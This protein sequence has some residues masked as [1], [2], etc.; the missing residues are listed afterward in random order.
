MKIGYLTDA[1]GDLNFFTNYCKISEV[2]K[3]ESYHPSYISL[4]LNDDCYFVFGGDTTDKGPGD[5]R[6]CKSL[7]KLK[8]KYPERVFLI[9]GNRDANK[10]MISYE[11]Q[12]FLYNK[13]FGQQ[14]GSF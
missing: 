1:E 5:I 4:S 9:L 7:I 12:R 11:K 8:Q 10:T 14:L 13:Q 6:I 2:L 3:I